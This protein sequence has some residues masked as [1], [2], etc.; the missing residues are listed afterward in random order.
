MWERSTPGAAAP[1][2]GMRSARGAAGRVSPAAFGC[3]PHRSTR[4]A[5]RPPACPRGSA[6]LAAGC[7]HRHDLCCPLAVPHGQ[8]CSPGTLL[9]PSPGCTT[10][11]G[12][13]GCPLHPWGQH[14]ARGISRGKG[15]A[16]RWLPDPPPRWSPRA[17][18]C[19]PPPWLLG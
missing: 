10:H 4:Q 11:A 16:G 12:V 1:E 14:P 7:R 17:A 2:E 9:H 5:P 3:F 13:P 6:S 15:A 18:C 8:G 19:Q